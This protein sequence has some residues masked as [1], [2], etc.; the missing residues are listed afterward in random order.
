M[1][2]GYK[3]KKAAEKRRKNLIRQG[4]DA[5]YIRVRSAKMGG[6]HKWLVEEF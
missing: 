1:V 2:G 3:S 6:V 4:W 5:G